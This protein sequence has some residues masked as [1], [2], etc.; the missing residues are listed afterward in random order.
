MIF[1]THFL[2][3]QV[4]RDFMHEFRKEHGDS[5]FSFR[6]PGEDGFFKHL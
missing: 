2:L 6:M 3:A 4:V 5:E 1:E